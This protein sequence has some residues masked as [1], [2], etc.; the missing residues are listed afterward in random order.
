MVSRVDI[1]TQLQDHFCGLADE[2]Y[3]SIGV[4]QVP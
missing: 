3:Q 2:M 1:I 4:L